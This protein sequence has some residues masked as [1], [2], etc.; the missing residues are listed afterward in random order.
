MIRFTELEQ[1]ILTGPEAM[2]WLGLEHKSS[3]DALVAS[4]RLIPLRIARDHRFTIAE[5]RRMAE[6]EVALE[7]KKRTNGQPEAEGTSPK[8][9][10]E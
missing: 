10:D 6:T 5:L 7:R 2:E 9:P 1:E 4:G 3:L 8:I